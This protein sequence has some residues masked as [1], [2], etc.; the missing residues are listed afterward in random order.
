MSI[1][2]IVYIASSC[3]SAFMDMHCKLKDAKE[4]PNLIF[5]DYQKEDEYI[6][7][8]YNYL[9]SNRMFIV[10]TVLIKKPVL[11]SNRREIFIT[12]YSTAFS[13]DIKDFNELMNN[14]KVYIF[15]EWETMW[16]HYRFQKRFPFRKNQVAKFYD[17]H[18]YIQ[19]EL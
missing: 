16:L 17:I 19:Q 18:I 2:L 11:I 1:V 15:R 9:D 10:D 4:S 8:N 6:E 14:K 12:D 3:N 13:I 5:Y 7:K